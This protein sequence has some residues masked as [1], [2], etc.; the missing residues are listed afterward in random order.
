MSTFDSYGLRRSVPPGADPLT[1]SAAPDSTSIPEGAIGW[2][3]P[4]GRVVKPKGDTPP[5]GART[6]E[7]SG[8]AWVPVLDDDGLAQA[9]REYAAKVGWTEADAQS[10]LAGPSGYAQVPG[11]PHLSYKQHLAAAGVTS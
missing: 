1:S 6:L 9:V 4:D 5:F 3:L 2:Q 7:Y 10:F 11:P 8:G